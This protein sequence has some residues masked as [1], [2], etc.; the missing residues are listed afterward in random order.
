VILIDG[1]RLIGDFND[2][3]MVM[4]IEGVLSGRVRHVS[5]GVT[6]NILL[7]SS[8]KSLPLYRTVQSEVN[9]VQCSC[10]N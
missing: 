9:M 1:L 6:G 10:V 5:N 3:D 4:Y 2:G 7:P 8:M